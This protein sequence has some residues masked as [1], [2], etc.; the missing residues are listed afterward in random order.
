MLLA[1][2]MGS[3]WRV[4]AALA[5]TALALGCESPS[6][7][8]SPAP[9][10]S[11]IPDAAPVPSAMASA[12]ADAS[13]WE[14]YESPAG[15]GDAGMLA[16]ALSPYRAELLAQDLRSRVFEAGRVTDGRRTIVVEDSFVVAQ[17]DEQ[18]PVDQVADEVRRVT[19]FL[20]RTAFTHRLYHAVRQRNCVTRRTSSAT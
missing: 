12:E 2:V 1:L 15:G 17:G 5:V 10:S 16:R 11:A 14:R 20:W 4:P 18:A 3:P 9:P 7:S 19:Q 13:A 8:V 6:G